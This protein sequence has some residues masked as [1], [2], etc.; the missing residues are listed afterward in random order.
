MEYYGI[1]YDLVIEHH[2]IKGQKWGDRNGPP[3]PLDAGS[4]SAA[5]KKAGTSGWTQDAKKEVRRQEVLGSKRKSGDTILKR[6]HFSAYWRR[7]FRI[8]QR[9]IRFI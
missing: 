5:Q 7:K 2:G 9:S 3:Y 4:H 8:H 6:N 1:H